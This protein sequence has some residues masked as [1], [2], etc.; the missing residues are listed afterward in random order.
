M[1]TKLLREHREI[2]DHTLRNNSGL[3]CG[4]SQEMQYL[5]DLGL[6]VYAGKKSFVP[7]P[8]FKLAPNWRQKMID[9]G[10]E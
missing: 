2:L 6:M 8:Y 3:F 5:V 7:D 1:A 4:D 9:E 10:I